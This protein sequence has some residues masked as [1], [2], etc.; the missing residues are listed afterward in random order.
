MGY[1]PR[2]SSRG[3]IRRPS[4]SLT[5]RL[6]FTL[7][8]IGAAGLGLGLLLVWSSLGVP[9]P[10]SREPDTFS[11]RSRASAPS[12]A[13]APG[14]GTAA[15]VELHGPAMPVPPEAAAEVSPPD[16]GPLPPGE[17]PP[18]QLSVFPG[19]LA[20]T[21]CVG[22]ERPGAAFPCPRDRQLEAAA[23]RILM[24]LP[25]CADPP[26]SPGAADVRLRFSGNAS[27]EVLVRPLRG[28]EPLDPDAL[29]A[30]TGDRF[31]ELRTSLRS[32]RVVVSIRLK[33]Q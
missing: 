14:G 17:P 27:P 31:A 7:P 13:G 22:L 21:Q 15:P 24:S 28:Q 33:L 11:P 2:V 4:A 29:L 9:H 6:P 1:E 32:R 25:E 18:P 5:R 20:Y 26:L 12:A 3:P 10:M 16:A 23:W 8:L 19:R 30:C